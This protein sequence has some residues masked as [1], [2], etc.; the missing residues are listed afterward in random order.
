MKKLLGGQWPPAV[1]LCHSAALSLLPLHAQRFS[2]SGSL[3]VT[4]AQGPSDLFH[5]QVLTTAHEE[6]SAFARLYAEENEAEL[7]WEG[8]SQVTQPGR[9]RTPDI[10]ILQPSCHRPWGGLLPT[11]VIIGVHSEFKGLAGTTILL[12]KVFP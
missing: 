5:H 10:L 11:L 4:T 12:R 8:P 3:S 1:P 6:H 2:R 9:H 7:T